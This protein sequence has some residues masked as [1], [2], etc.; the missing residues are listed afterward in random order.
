MT[1]LELVQ[2]LLGEADVNEDITTTAGAVGEVRDCC[3]WV[4]DAYREIQGTKLYSFL[5]ENPTKS[6]LANTNVLA[7]TLDATRYDTATLWVTIPGNTS[8]RRLDYLPW[9][10]FALNYQ[11]LQAAG[12]P[13]VWT[14]R[15]DKAIVFNAKALSTAALA[16]TVERYKTGQVISVDADVPLM[17]D[18][19]HMLI[20]WTALKKYAGFDEA[21]NQRAI[22]LDEMKTM[23]HALDMRCLPTFTFGPP[24]GDR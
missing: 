4:T 15:P 21:G 18:D 11:V 1:Y 8:P 6:M 14:V 22:A 19:L 17:P 7:D 2:R 23:E 20:V 16:F 13:T 3:R 9:Q 5:W 12:N 24:L 10:D